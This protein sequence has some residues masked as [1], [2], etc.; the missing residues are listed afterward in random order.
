MNTSV[1]RILSFFRF[2]GFLLKVFGQ[3]FDTEIVPANVF[4]LW[5]GSADEPL[6]KGMYDF[7]HV[8]RYF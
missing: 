6:G 4:K 5:E 1:I 8:D 2:A 7:Q 3:L